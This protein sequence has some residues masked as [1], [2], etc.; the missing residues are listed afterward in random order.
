MSE[1]HPITAEKPAK[2]AKPYEDFPLFAHA[3]G[4]WAKKIRGKLQYF[5]KWADGAD[6]AFEKYQQQKDD[7]HA[8]KTPRADTSALTVRDLAEDFL[9]F[10]KSVVES[11][12]LTQRSWDDYKAAT[13]ILVSH[14]GKN[15]LVDDIGPDDFAKLRKKLAK[16]WG[17]VT[18]GNVIQ[19]IRVVF[20]FAS[21]QQLIERPV[22]YGQGFKRPSRKTIRKDKATKGH[23]LFT[24][25]EVRR[26]LNAAGVH[27]KAMRLLGINCGFGNTDCGRLPLSAINL[28][29]G[30]IDFPRP[31]TGIARRCALWPETAAAIR[32]SLANRPKPKNAD[33]AGLVFIT[34][35]GESWGKDTTDNPVS[36]ETAKLLHALKINGR[37]GLG[38][39]TLRHTFRTTA[40]LASQE[41]AGHVEGERPAA[42]TQAWSAPVVPS[43]GRSPRKSL[44]PRQPFRGHQCELWGRLV[45]RHRC[46]RK[47]RRHNLLQNPR[48]DDHAQQS[49][50][51][52][53]EPDHRR[54]GP[55]HHH[56]R[57]LQR[58]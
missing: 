22:A 53:Q 25:E 42:A 47:Q 20:K 36:K 27:L 29:T 5:G 15:R 39:Y 56:R 24:A 51:H 16:P 19:R 12:E 32:E 17:P 10:K 54:L 52:R 21:D 4:R 44:G 50:Y 6:A 28:E 58:R 1:V 31:K 33:D 57:P 8:G 14:F 46:Q 2:P 48:H 23:K 37:K 9:K 13:D 49:D 40:S 35:F 38:F 45:T 7:L 41:L 55:E 43:A 34:K 26:L 3:S 30:W 11:A 18:L